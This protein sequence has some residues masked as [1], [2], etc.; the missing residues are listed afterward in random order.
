MIPLMPLFCDGCRCAHARTRTYTHV[1]KHTQTHES[2]AR[3]HAHAQVMHYGLHFK[4]GADYGFDKHWHYDF[5]VTS[6][7]PYKSTLNNRR[8]A[9][10]FPN[11]PRVSSL[12]N[13]DDFG[14]YYKD[15]L[16]IETVATMNAGICEYHL[17]HCPVS[18]ELTKAC[19]EALSILEEASAVRRSYARC[20]RR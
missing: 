2:I 17:Q 20:W 7:P 4:I 19:A 6:C 8:T 5:D 16:S 15:V 10:M 1:P 9:G 11:P 3:T 12:S 13:K 14:N 18:E